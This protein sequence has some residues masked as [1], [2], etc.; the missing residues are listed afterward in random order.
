M[1]FAKQI[2][3]DT[4][5]EPKALTAYGLLASDEARKALRS[6]RSSPW[7]AGQPVKAKGGPSEGLAFEE[8]KSED[9]QNNID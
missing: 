9:S 1:E 2:P 3:A 6:L 5:L 4:T 8:S 7:V